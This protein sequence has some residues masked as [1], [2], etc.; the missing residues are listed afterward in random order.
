MLLDCDIHLLKKDEKKKEGEEDVHN[1]M[2]KEEEHTMRMKVA[3]SN[4]FSMSRVDKVLC[5][6][7]L[8]CLCKTKEVVDIAN[9]R[10]IRGKIDD[11]RM[12]LFYC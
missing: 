8:C 9:K 4:V 3:Q 5:H 10:E 2:R 12:N 11:G 1:L 7:H 6:H